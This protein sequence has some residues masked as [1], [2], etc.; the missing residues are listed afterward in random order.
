MNSIEEAEE[1]L[2]ETVKAWERIRR[3]KEAERKR[4]DR[5]RRSVKGTT[6]KQ[7]YAIEN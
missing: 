7:D 4:E 6:L 5:G 2:R 3:R 1:H